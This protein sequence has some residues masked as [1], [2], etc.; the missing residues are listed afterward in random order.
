[1]LALDLA[2]VPTEA[3]LHP[4]A[5]VPNQ[6]VPDQHKHLLPSAANCRHRADAVRN[7]KVRCKQ[8]PGWQE[9]SLSRLPDL[10]TADSVPNTQKLNKKAEILERG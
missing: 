4:L 1:M 5:D 10:Y 6:A 2:V 8:L 9:K 3:A 7:G